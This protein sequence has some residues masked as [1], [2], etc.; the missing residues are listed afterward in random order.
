[1]GVRIGPFKTKLFDRRALKRVT[2]TMEQIQKERARR[3]FAHQFNYALSDK[4]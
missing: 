2:T 3:N 4:R 1:L